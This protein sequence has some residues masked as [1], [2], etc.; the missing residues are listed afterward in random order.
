MRRLAY[1]YIPNQHS[2]P[3][4]LTSSGLSP[5]TWMLAAGCLHMR[6]PIGIVMPPSTQQ[7][8]QDDILAMWPA[9]ACPC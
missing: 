8:R 7:P 6:L 2:Q 5:C 9:F 4:W 3:A 1:K